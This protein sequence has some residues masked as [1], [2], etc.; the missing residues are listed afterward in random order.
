[1]N[2]LEEISGG[3]VSISGMIFP[4]IYFYSHLTPLKLHRNLGL[5]FRKTNEQTKPNRMSML[6]KKQNKI[7][8]GR[9]NICYLCSFCPKSIEKLM[10]M[11]QT[12]CW[13]FPYMSQPQWVLYINAHYF[14]VNFFSSG[15]FLRHELDAQRDTLV[16]TQAQNRRTLG[17][18]FSFKAK[19]LG[20][21]I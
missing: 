14:V 17:S 3:S 2:V 20:Q 7:S 8:K 12:F 18:N 13:A 16:N 19:F 9:E 11:C 5:P 1:M 10:A 21:I 4:Y 6:K 15:R